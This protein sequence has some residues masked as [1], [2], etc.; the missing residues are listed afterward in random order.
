MNNK[1]GL[2]RG[3]VE[4]PK[5]FKKTFKQLISYLKD[6]KVGIFF[7]IIFAMC[8]GKT[9]IQDIW[10]LFAQSLSNHHLEIET[11][12]RIYNWVCTI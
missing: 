9:R 2:I 12:K 1:R 3:T 7:V 11:S 4:K 5:D 6:Y 8:S 10:K